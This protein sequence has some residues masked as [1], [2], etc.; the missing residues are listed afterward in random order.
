MS[1]LPILHINDIL[2]GNVGAEDL[3]LTALS[4][5]HLGKKQNTR[6]TGLWKLSFLA[7]PIIHSQGTRTDTHI[8]EVS[9]GGLPASLHV[10]KANYTSNKLISWFTGL[11]YSINFS[12]EDTQPQLTHTHTLVHMYC[13]HIIHA[14]HTAQGRVMAYR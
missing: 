3:A 9:D 1:C 7:V 5:E 14:S 6:W 8:N 11:S 10:S 12:L 4:S 13:T 2:R